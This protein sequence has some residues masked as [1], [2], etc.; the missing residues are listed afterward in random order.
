MTSLC[1]L[2]KLGY[3]QKPPRVATKAAE[4]R[5]AQVIF[6]KKATV[7]EICSAWGFTEAAKAAVGP[8]GEGWSSATKVKQCLSDG[9][10]AANAFWEAISTGPDKKDRVTQACFEV[11]RVLAGASSGGS[12]AAASAPASAPAPAPAPAPASSATAGSMHSHMF[13]F[14]LSGDALVQAKAMALKLIFPNNRR[15]ENDGLV[16]AGTFDAVLKSWVEAKLE[17]LVHATNGAPLVDMGGMLQLVVTV[18]DL[19]A[20]LPADGGGSG[21]GG[22][23]SG[24]GGGGGKTSTDDLAKAL[25]GTRLPSVK[26]ENGHEK[27]VPLPG[28]MLPLVQ[29]ESLVVK[30]D[31][32]EQAVALGNTPAGALAGANLG[33]MTEEVNADTGKLESFKTTDAASSTGLCRRASQLRRRPASS[34][35]H[36]RYGSCTRRRQSLSI[37]PRASSSRHQTAA[38]TQAASRRRRRWSPTC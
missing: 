32:L 21:G 13:G 25:D 23:G 38:K 16:R 1:K 29:A 28:G 34:A 17:V 15:Y 14:F 8:T 35:A 33:V 11:V 6:F 3:S 30:H 36:E 2:R 9:S 12:G 22:G 20:V 18:V 7:T 5:W 19:D 27:L 24:G 10:A 37:T 26:G 31:I 4:M